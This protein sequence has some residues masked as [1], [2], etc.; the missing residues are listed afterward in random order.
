MA[1]QTAA[2]SFVRFRRVVARSDSP[3]AE[4]RKVAHQ[5]G[6]QKITDDRR[7]KGHGPRS[8]R[9][10]TTFAVDRAANKTMDGSEGSGKT[11][12]QER[13]RENHDLYLQ[14]PTFKFRGGARLYRAASPGTEGSTPFSIR[15]VLG[16]QQLTTGNT[17]EDFAHVFARDRG[18]V[19]GLPAKPPSIAEPKVPAQ[20]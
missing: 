12:Y 2:R 4:E 3:C 13:N 17:R 10:R 16:G 7:P 18:V 6:P 15:T 14:A 1:G 19:V 9:V 5:R 11:D 20:S 8:P